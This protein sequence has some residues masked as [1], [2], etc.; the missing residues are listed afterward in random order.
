M[1]IWVKN[2]GHTKTTSKSVSP[3]ECLDRPNMM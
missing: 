1:I 3:V 2:G